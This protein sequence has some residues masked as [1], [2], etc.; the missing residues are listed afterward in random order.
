MAGKLY[1]Q[2]QGYWT[3][4][5]SAVGGAALLAAGAHWLWTKLSVLD[6]SYGLYVQAAV[7]VAILAGGGLLLYWLVGTN[8][9]TCDFLIATEGEMKKVN[10]PARREVF[11]STWVV[12]CSV[13]LFSLILFV[14]DLLFSLL[15]S[16]MGVLEVGLWSSLF[17]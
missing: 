10:W 3:R 11:G 14:S 6:R 12:I 17:G 16:A 1:K 7:A 4:L 9:R 8:Q 15:F 13:I 2:G 5:V